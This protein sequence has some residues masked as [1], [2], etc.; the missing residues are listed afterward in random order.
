[1]IIAP[2]SGRLGRKTIQEGQQIQAG[3]S[4]V[5]I[6]NE[7]EK[8]VTANFKE[9]QIENMKVGQD[10]EI[11]IDGFEDKIYYGKLKQLLVRQVQNSHYCPR[12]TLPEIL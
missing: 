9:T 11:K 1:M 10:V 7:E 2:Y 12:I 3:Q 4:L 8:W 5:P 6:I